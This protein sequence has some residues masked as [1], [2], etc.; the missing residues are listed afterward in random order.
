VCREHLLK[1]IELASKRAGLHGFETVK[2]PHTHMHTLT[3]SKPRLLTESRS[4]FSPRPMSQ[5]GVLS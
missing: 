2:V 4:A 5:R 3:F 1:E